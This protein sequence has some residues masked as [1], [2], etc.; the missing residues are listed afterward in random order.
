[1]H[2][3]SENSFNRLSMSN[4]P[5]EDSRMWAHLVGVY[6]LTALTMHWLARECRWYTRLRHR[7]LTRAEP[8]HRCVFV[9][10]VPPEL[11]GSKRLAEYFA[12]L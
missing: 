5:T 4:M 7:F 1:M 9:R 3:Q 10:Q 11:R 6:L 2:T 12:K 8:R